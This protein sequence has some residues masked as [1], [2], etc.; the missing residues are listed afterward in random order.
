VLVDG[1]VAGAWKIARTKGRAALEI[2]L[3]GKLS[4]KD[5]RT[6]EKEGLKLLDFAAAEA[7]AR[8]ACFLAR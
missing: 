3:F 8:A 6:V 5:Q 7:K 4:K 2:E 1:F